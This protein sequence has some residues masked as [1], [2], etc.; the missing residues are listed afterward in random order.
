MMEEIHDKNKGLNQPNQSGQMMDANNWNTAS[1]NDEIDLFDIIHTIWTGRVKIVAITAVFCL[2]AGLYAFTATTW[3]SSEFKL[4]TAKATDLYGINNSK[5]VSVSPSD[6]LNKVKKVIFSKEHFY[7]Y[8]ISDEV[9]ESLSERLD[10]LTDHQFAYALFDNQ[11]DRLLPA[12]AKKDEVVTEQIYI[13]LKFDYPKGELGDEFL[14]GYYTWATNLV[15]ND[16]ANEFK[17]KRENELRLNNKQMRTMLYTF[18]KDMN[19]QITMLEE[20]DRLARINIEDQISALRD[21]LDMHNEQRIYELSENIAIAKSLGM[22]A[23]ETYS[24][25][26]GQNN[27]QNPGSS[28]LQADYSSPDKLPLFYRGFTSLMAEKVERERRNKDSFPSAQISSLEKQ[29]KL[30]KENR[31]IEKLKARKAPEVFIAG[32]QKLEKRNTLLAELEIDVINAS[33]YEV[34][35]LPLPGIVPIK[36]KKLLILVLGGILGG[37]FGVVFVLMRSTVKSRRAER[38][39][40]AE[41]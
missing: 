29:L 12:K 1:R 16:I 30:L 3:Y 7:K 36:P 17:L 40:A 6:A 20:S 4:S 9:K 34:E 5:I 31:E 8:Y 41:K 19:N 23:P 37:M 14:L 11:I 15:K 39:L 25:S 35:V 38:L 2:M 32:Y 26:T 10:T 33:L 28:I 13:G 27:A 21:E 24:G 18:N 22:E